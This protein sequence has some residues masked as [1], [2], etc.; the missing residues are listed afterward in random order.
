MTAHATKSAVAS[1]VFVRILNYLFRRLGLFVADHDKLVLAA[2]LLLTVICSVKIVFTPQQDDIRTGYTPRGARSREEMAVFNEFFSYSNRDPIAVF[3]FVVAKDGGSMARIEHLKEAVRQLDYAGTNVTHRGRSF[4][5]LCTDFCEINEPIRQFYNGLVMKGNSSELD[6]PISLTFPT[7][8]VLGTKLDLSPNFFGVETNATD[9][10]VTFLKVV[11]VQYR[12]GPPDDWDKYDL[13]HY[14]RGLSAY[15]QKEM[16]SDLLNIYAFSLTYTSDEIVRTGLSIFPYLAVGFT[17]MSI[18]SVATVFYS[19]M[20]MNQWSNHKITNAVFGCICPLLATS[21]ALGFL[22][23]CGFR[24]GTILC[25]TPFL[26]LAIGVDDAYLMMHSWMRISTNDSTMTRRERIAHMLVDVG[27]S[28]T[29]TSLTNFLAFLVGYYTPTPEIQL[30]CIGNSVAILFDYF[31]QITMY[32]ALMSITGDFEM[33]KA[34]KASNDPQWVTL[35]KQMFSDYLD[36]YSQWLASKFTATF[37]LI[38]LIIYWFLSILGATQIQIILSADKLVLQDSDLITM[39]HLREH[40][41]LVNYTVANLFVQNPGDLDDPAR[42]R[43]VNSLV[44]AFESYPECLGANFSHYFVRDYKFFR[45]MVELEEEEAFGE[46]P[47][48]NETFTKAAMQS[49]FSWPE[50]KHWNGFVKF[51][52][53]GKLTRIWITISYHGDRMGDNVYRK[54]ILEKWR[55]TA[56][57]YPALNVS[58]FDDYAPFLDQ[59][60]SML[61]ATISTSICTLLCMMLVCFIFMYNL[62]TV[63]V[64]TISITSICIGVFG[65]LSFWGVDLDPIS[66]ATTIM[67]IGF[68]VDFPAHITFH[69]FREGLEDPD[70]TPARRIAKSLAAIGF[71]LLQC[72]ISTV[73]FVLCLLFV[74]TYMSEVFVK[75]MVLVVTLGLIHGLIFVPAFLCALTSIYNTFFKDRFWGSQSSIADWFT[76]K[77]SRPSSVGKVSGTVPA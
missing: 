43:M 13:Q 70:S 61:P 18:F 71:P 33:R 8:E 4:Y 68:S 21:S 32:A 9:H 55:R 77:D 50:F 27:P 65:M 46:G 25:V 63:I 59:L 10:T 66:M 29:I 11:G 44:A 15:F 3:A 58:V 60:D 36:E 73:L 47:Q 64:A 41:I 34:S 28:V 22:F 5:S 57:S 52:E 31:Y 19:S 2:T 69:Y 30:F 42:L 35:K 56:D 14:E 49:F 53:K 54:G 37:L 6:Q 67:S 72:G 75:T 40:Y 62:F 48:R 1:P 16:Q 23:W 17:I 20:S 51:D 45:E 39:N 26:V 12:A 38:V 7:M 76:R 74:K 24:F